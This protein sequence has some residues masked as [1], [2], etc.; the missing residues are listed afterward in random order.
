[1]QSEIPEVALVKLDQRNSE[2][3]LIIPPDDFHFAKYPKYF[4]EIEMYSQ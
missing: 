3:K 1:M 4:Q 2:S